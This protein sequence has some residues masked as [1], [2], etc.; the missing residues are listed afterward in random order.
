MERHMDADDIYL[1]HVDQ[2]YGKLFV[3]TVRRFQD[4]FLRDKTPDLDEAFALAVDA[5]VCLL[6]AIKIKAEIGGAA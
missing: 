3:A 2:P 4:G 5:A 6:P 1:E